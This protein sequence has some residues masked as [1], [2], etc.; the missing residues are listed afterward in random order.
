ME[1]FFNL[2]IA[3]IL[4]CSMI[5]SC[6]DDIVADSEPEIEA[7]GF[8]DEKEAVKAVDALYTNGV[9]SFYGE[10]DIEQGPM[11]ALG[12]FLSGFFDN[13][14]TSATSISGYSRSLN[15]DAT[16]IS[17]YLNKAW[18]GCYHTIDFANTAITNIPN[19]GALSVNRRNVLLAEARFFRAF[20][21]FFLVKA[22]GDIPL[23]TPENSWHADIKRTPAKEIYAFIEED[24]KYSIHNLPDKSFVENSFRISR[25]VAETLLADV[26]LTMSGHP[27]NDNR[28]ASALAMARSVIGSG[29]HQLMINEDSLETSAYTK[30]RTI[31]NNAELIYMYKNRGKSNISL[32]SFTLTKSA[33]SWGVIKLDA[34]NNAYYPTRGFLNVYDSIYDLRMHERQFF[35]T[36]YKYDK[37]NKTIIETFHQIPYMW[38]DADAVEQTGISARDIPVY[39]YAEVLLIAAEA[40]AQTEGVTP[41][42]AAYLAEVRARAYTGSTRSEIEEKLKTLDKE[43]FI[44]QVW[45]ERMRELPFEMK[46][47]DDIRRTRK[48]PVT[49]SSEKG[50]AVFVNVVGAKN[51]LGKI[52]ETKHLLLPIPLSVTGNYKSVIQ[53]PGYE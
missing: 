4:G 43:G 18:Q 52:F 7:G 21:Y 36:F 38:Y 8:S 12:G 11:L 42:A 29:K 24:L 28:Y 19:T 9:P 48:Y 51:S 35:H 22:F 44:K 10:G 26:Y 46:I 39:R 37:D 2:L 13:E 45:I 40:T 15:I 31:N 34:T 16:N 41:E 14:S 20:N 25:T 30:L 17:S 53:N 32:S 49:S 5:V 1:K 47:W 6:Q 3:S 50:T 33:V 23:V 27:V